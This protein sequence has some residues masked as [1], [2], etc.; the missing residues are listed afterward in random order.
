MLR[1]RKVIN[2]KNHK[3]ACSRR[4]GRQQQIFDPWLHL[5]PK[6]RKLLD[7]LWAGLFQREILHELP[8]HKLACYFDSGF[9]RP[10]K[11]LYTSLSV[12]LSKNQRIPRSLSRPVG[13]MNL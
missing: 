5:G 10:S 8:V 12:L 3:P 4:A 11:E 2:I 13:M 6:R 1:D 9:S 7:E